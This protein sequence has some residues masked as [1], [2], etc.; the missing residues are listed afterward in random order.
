LK[1]LK[2]RTRVLERPDYIFCLW[3]KLQVSANAYP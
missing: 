3:S 2:M 1:D